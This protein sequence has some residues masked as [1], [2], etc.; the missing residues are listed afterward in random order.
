[1]SRTGADETTA[2]SA[3][4]ATFVASSQTKPS[5]LRRVVRGAAI[6]P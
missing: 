1:M 2:L 5:F 4:K 6:V 3:V